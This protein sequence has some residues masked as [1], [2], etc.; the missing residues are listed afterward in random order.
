[1]LLDDEDVRRLNRVLKLSPDAV[2]Y[3]LMQ[4]P[5]L[6]L[7][8]AM[9][10][11]LRVPRVE[12]LDLPKGDTHHLYTEVKIMRDLTMDWARPHSED[13]ISCGNYCLVWMR[14]LGF[15]QASTGAWFQPFGW[16][17]RLDHPL[18]QEISFFSADTGTAYD[19]QI[20]Q[21][22]EACRRRTL[23]NRASAILLPHWRP[24]G[25]QVREHTR[26]LLTEIVDA[27]R[28][29]P[30]VSSRD[31]EEIVAE[32]LKMRGLEVTVTP[33]TR[34]GGRDVIA[35][36]E[37]IPGEPAII[38]VETKKRAVVGIEDLRACLYA[39]RN[40]P[41]ILFATSGRFSAGV[42]QEAAREEN[43]F[44]LLLKDGLA[45]RQW[46]HEY[47]GQARPELVPGTI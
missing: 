11:E 24:Q 38:A 2:P 6:L 19:A 8:D 13:D 40:F 46:I 29:L 47:F 7:A 44:R 10:D 4:N 22:V 32:L 39:N 35:R 16:G 26:T 31:L 15:R 43:A 30:S 28:G 33:R 45:L 9:F 21:L 12:D 1:M 14:K 17:G 27:S 42:V 36:G 18:G 34:D 5:H 37:L 20:A 3:H 25:S 23:S 41:L